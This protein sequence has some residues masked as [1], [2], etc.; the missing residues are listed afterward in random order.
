MKE[1]FTPGDTPLEVSFYDNGK[2]FT[3]KA[4]GKIAVT[5]ELLINLENRFGASVS[6]QL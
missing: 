6:I 2:P 5:K 3:L 4:K 1:L